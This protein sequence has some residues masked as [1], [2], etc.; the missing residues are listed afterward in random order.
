[1]RPVSAKYVVTKHA[2]KGV[3]RVKYG[4][5]IFAALVLFTLDA[6]QAAER[7]GV[8]AGVVGNV[9][10]THA[11][12]P[13]PVAAKS[14][15]DMFVGDRLQ[16]AAGA[17]MQ[18][19]LIDESV[20]TIGP[21]TNLVIDEFVFAADAKKNQISATIGKGLLNYVS[22]KVA[23]E[24]PSAVRIKT[25]S[26]ILGVRG[27]A[28]FVMDDPQSGEGAQFIG[29]LGPGDQNDGNLA[30]GGITVTSGTESVDVHRA[31]FGVLSAPGQELSG[32]EPTPVRL[33]EAMALQ[34]TTGVGMGAAAGGGA[35]DITV[36]DTLEASG[37][38]VADTRLNLADT[39]SAISSLGSAYHGAGSASEDAIDGAVQQIVTEDQLAAAR[40]RAAA[41]LANVAALT[42]AAEQAQA[43]AAAAA[44]ALAQ[45]QAAAL[46]GAAEQA[47]AQAA[48]A[49]AAAALAQAQAT[50]QAAA[51]A[52]ELAA[53]QA[54]GLAA[55]IAASAPGS[56]N[57]QQPAGLAAA[58]AAEQAAA[59]A[60][61][62]AQAAAVAA[63]QATAEAQA[64]AVAAA[65]AAAE[66]QAA[67]VT[68]AQAAA[69]AQATAAQAAAVQA[70][71]I[72][73]LQPVAQIPQP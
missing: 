54:A 53:A 64:A 41:A 50:A 25:S 39:G 10:V 63:A 45:A 42:G 73:Q 17:R 5:G 33:V 6:A 14:G 18:V 48:A 28:L 71:A 21:S 20:F 19:L 34:L 44:A 55:Q 35:P 66:A 69:A 30:A 47:Q 12:Q 26:A 15:M 9:L 36:E 38:A 60:A 52:A 24:N 61:T 8:A 59:Q 23:K 43:Q 13:G 58:R 4:A 46:T 49:A 11:G 65:Q 70:Q 62:Q 67:A 7:A 27:T 72:A 3:T 1:M 57:Q 68:A 56:A 32:P 29:L 51:Q 40:A 31:G 16:S 2:N 22:G 37:Q